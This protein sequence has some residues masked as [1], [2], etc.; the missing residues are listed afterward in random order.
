MECASNPPYIESDRATPELASLF[1]QVPA[2]PAFIYD[3]SLIAHLGRLLAQAR[4]RSGCRMLYSIKALPFVPVLE[5]LAP[6]MDGFSVSSL[7]E[8]RLASTVTG[9]S[10]HITSPG[11]RA[12]EM[13][14]IGQL[15]DF[16]AFNSLGQFERLCP[17]LSERTRAGLRINPQYSFLNDPRFDPC[18]PHSKLG[19]P[20][21]QLAAAYAE[22]DSLR[23]RLSGLH[24]HTLFSSR[25]FNPLRDLVDLLERHLAQV[26]PR[27]TWLNLGG[28]YLFEQE[29]DLDGLCEIASRLRQRYDLSVY[30]EPGKALIGRA[31][32][33]AASVIDVFT[34]DGKTVAVLDSSVNHAPEIFEYQSRPEPTWHEPEQGF[35][36][37]LAGCTCLAGDVFGEYRFER[38]LKLGDRLAFQHIGAYS[39]IKANRFNGY[40]L[41]SIHAWD[42][43]STLRPMKD[44]RYEDYLVQWLKS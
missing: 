35:P 11:L 23:Q 12:E 3:E 9:V 6:W 5:L 40:N 37:I 44:Y 31:G 41:P 39:L 33:L 14:E 15:C 1:E 2:T 29:A 18:R 26:L 21:R 7:F 25:S 19:V 38:P 13:S 28:G 43:A 8:A 30:F 4:Q 42:G 22:D 36:A 17:L 34:S 27:L 10:R 16:V 32:Y 20:L 24:L